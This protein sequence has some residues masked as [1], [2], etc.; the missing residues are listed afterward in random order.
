MKR[1]KG[2]E[3]VEIRV[4]DSKRLRP[5][6]LLANAIVE[7]AAK[8]W[9]SARKGE[10]RSGEETRGFYTE[11]RLEIERF[12][13]SKRFAIYTKLNPDYLLEQLEK[14]HREKGE[15]EMRR[16]EYEIRID[17]TIKRGE[18]DGINKDDAYNKARNIAYRL[19]GY[20]ETGFLESVI[21]RPVKKVRAVDGKDKKN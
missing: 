5:Y 19:S 6:E 15:K 14:Y 13:R 21:V 4:E 18:I 20:G 17:A 9:L 10:D 12:F 11:R 1:L 8:D 16:Y 3:N 7:Q 2:E